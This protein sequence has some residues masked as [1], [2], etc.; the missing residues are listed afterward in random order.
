M[1]LCGVD[2][3]YSNKYGLFNTDRYCKTY[4]KLSGVLR[5]LEMELLAIGDVRER[6]P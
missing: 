5:V 2:L 6:Q 3:N 1:P 4:G